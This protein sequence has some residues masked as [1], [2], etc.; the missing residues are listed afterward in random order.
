MRGRHK[1]VE[2]VSRKR[3]ELF[4]LE[5]D[6]LERR[7]LSSGE[8]ALRAGLEA[9]LRAAIRAA[10]EKGARFGAGGTVELSP[11]ERQNLEELGYAGKEK[12]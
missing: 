2:D 11:E 9:E 4:D 7:D 8:P 3:I 6:P 12:E 1:L 5:A 10:E